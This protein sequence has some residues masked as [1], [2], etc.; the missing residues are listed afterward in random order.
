LGI[1]YLQGDVTTTAWWDG[2]PFDGVLCNMALMDIDDLGGALVTAF[3]VLKP[4]GWFSMSILHPCFPGGDEG[5]EAGLS[6]WPPD[7]GYTWEGRWNTEGVG[8][9]GHADVNHRT[10]STYLN[11]ILEAGFALETFHEPPA[12]VPRYLAVVARRLH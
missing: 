6:S 3:R 2:R 8:V 7:R 1:Q 9:R 12:N 4:G 10:L 5:P 11:S